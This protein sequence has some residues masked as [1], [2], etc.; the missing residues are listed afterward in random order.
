MYLSARKITFTFNVGNVLSVT[1]TIVHGLYFIFNVLCNLND[2]WF[3]RRSVQNLYD[4]FQSIIQHCK[5]SATMSSNSY[6]DKSLRRNA[7]IKEWSQSLLWNRIPSEV[8]GMYC[9]QYRFS[10]INVFGVGRHSLF[11]EKR[12]FRPWSVRVSIWNRDITQQR[13]TSKTEAL[14][15]RCWY[16]LS[17][18][19]PLI[20]VGSR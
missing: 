2:N 19:D 10:R 14:G 3:T 7:H 6:G 8:G 4:K 11:P 16:S 5:R 17:V 18:I 12:E 9:S 15:R 13:L 20:Y 1:Y